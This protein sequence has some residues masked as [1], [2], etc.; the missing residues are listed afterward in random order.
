MADISLDGL[1]KNYA[2]RRGVSSGNIELLPGQQMRVTSCNMIPTALAIALIILVSISLLAVGAV[3]LFLYLRKT[4]GGQTP[5]EVAYEG[6][7]TRLELKVA[8]LPSLWEDERARSKR[9]ND[10][11]KAARKVA[12]E[13][14]QQIEE[15]I[16]EAGSVP[17]FDENGSD[18]I[19]MQ[20]MRSNMGVTPTSG[21]EN[22]VAE[23]AHLLR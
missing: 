12:D 6:R 7:L 15:L 5:P 4:I 3:G 20:P 16:E 18:Q 14:L 22:R 11:A 8:G 21:I 23:I 1:P 9:N 13:K 17:Q 2:S 10:A 19:E